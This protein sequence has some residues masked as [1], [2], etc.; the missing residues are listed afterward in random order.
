M[1]EGYH[2]IHEP[3]EKQLPRAPSNFYLPSPDVR[4]HSF[5]IRMTNHEIRGNAEILMTKP[6]RF[7]LQTA[8]IAGIAKKGD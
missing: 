5:Q 6:A 4:D 8:K 7:G 2:E 3:H 1:R